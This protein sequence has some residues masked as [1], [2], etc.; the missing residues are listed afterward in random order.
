MGS[1]VPQVRGCFQQTRQRPLCS[2]QYASFQV[3]RQ[4]HCTPVHSTD[5]VYRDLTNMRVRTPWI[6]ALRRQREGGEEL[7]REPATTMTSG[8][9]F[10]KAKKMSDSF[11]RVVR[12]SLDPHSNFTGSLTDVDL[13]DTISA[14]SVASGQLSQCQRARQDW[15]PVHGS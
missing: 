8:S 1:K 3:I 7:N 2:S 13:G 15:H 10:I 5:G 6:E 4:L 14:R 11:H 9:H 12:C